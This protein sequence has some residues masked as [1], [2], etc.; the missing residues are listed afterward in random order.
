[1]NLRKPTGGPIGWGAV[2]DLSSNVGRLEIRSEGKKASL[3]LIKGRSLRYVRGRFPGWVRK[4]EG[5]ETGG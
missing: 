5:G 1:V 4:R 3:N 2:C